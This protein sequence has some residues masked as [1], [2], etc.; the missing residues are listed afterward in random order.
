VISS[1]KNRSS[2]FSVYISFKL[3]DVGYVQP[4]QNSPRTDRITYRDYLYA[5]ML[6]LMVLKMTQIAA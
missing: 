3:D 2:M 5:W 6:T 4:F 1:R